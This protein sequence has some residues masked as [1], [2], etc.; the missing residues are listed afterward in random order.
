[1]LVLALVRKSRLSLLSQVVQVQV[2]VQAHVLLQVVQ[3]QV[4]Q[5]V[6]VKV[7]WLVQLKLMACRGPWLHHVHAHGTQ[8][9]RRRPGVSRCGTTVP[10]ARVE[11]RARERA[12][13]HEPGATP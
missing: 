11:G 1:V 12:R 4:L 3:V 9:K 5:Q 13:D 7:L 8:Q 6:L 10:A 2:Q